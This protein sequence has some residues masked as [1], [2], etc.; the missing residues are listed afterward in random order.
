[1]RFLAG[2]TPA[3]RVACDGRVF[4]ILHVANLEERGRETHLLVKERF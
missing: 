4:D 2:I 3:M 1:M